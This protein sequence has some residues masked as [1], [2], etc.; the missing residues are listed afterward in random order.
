MDHDTQQR[1]LQTVKSVSDTIYF[2]TTTATE[3]FLTN[4]SSCF[5]TNLDKFGQDRPKYPSFWY[6]RNSS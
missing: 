4:F 1:K 3:E 6:I 2:M 5:L